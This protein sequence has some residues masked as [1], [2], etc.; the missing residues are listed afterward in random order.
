MI[1][2]KKMAEM[3][4]IKKELMEGL[5]YR[6]LNS[7]L[8]INNVSSLVYKILEAGRISKELQIKIG[9]ILGGDGGKGDLYSDEKD[10]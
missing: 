3:A 8:P 5:D 10:R 6:F 4:K 2:R 7:Q 1:D 9:K